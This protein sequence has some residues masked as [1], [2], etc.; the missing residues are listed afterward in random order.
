MDAE[1][2]YKKEAACQADLMITD[3][4]SIGLGDGS[5]VLL[6]AGLLIDRIRQGLQIS[7][8]TSSLTTKD[9]LT[10]SDVPV[11]EAD[12]VYNLDLYFDGCD[13]VDIDLNAFKSGSGIHTSE[14]LLASMAKK[15]ILLADSSK[16]VEKLNNK[17]PL[18]LELLPRSVNY[19]Q[20][21]LKS[22]FAEIGL[23]PRMNEYSDQW[24]RT[25]DGNYLIDCY[26][27]I[28]PDLSTIQAFCKNITGVIDHSLFFQ[29]AHELI[30]SGDDGTHMLYREHS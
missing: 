29:L 13:Q 1:K 5:T 30:V 27:K 20:K 21:Q 7:I 10:K 2:N 8:C 14:K 6:L 17:F 25:Q 26:F 19:V 9:F 15:F 16:F 23:N 18:V 28:L 24:V 4:I 11:V 3:N 12:A 22:R